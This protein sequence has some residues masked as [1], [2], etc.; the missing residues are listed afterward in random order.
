MT[1]ENAIAIL[2]SRKSEV[3]TYLED[4]TMN[5]TVR[6]NIFQCAAAYDMA[7]SALNGQSV[8]F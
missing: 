4:I 1:K 6:T 2:A 8:D 7:I 5:E 3:L